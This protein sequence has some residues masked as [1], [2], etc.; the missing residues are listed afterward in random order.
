M[1]QFDLA[2]GISNVELVPPSKADRVKLA[3][4][5]MPPVFSKAELTGI[6]PEISDRTVKRVL[7]ELR[8][9]GKIEVAKRGR[10][11]MWRKM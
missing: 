8:A 9:K 7:D 2:Y 4:Q 3:V 5:V 6:C 10:N 1:V 11:A